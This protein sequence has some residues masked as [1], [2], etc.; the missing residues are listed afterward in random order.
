MAESTRAGELN[1][2]LRRLASALFEHARRDAS[3]RASTRA[4]IDVRYRNGCGSWIDKICIKTSD[5]RVAWLS[6]TNE[7]RLSLSRLGKLR[8]GDLPS[9]WCGLMLEVDSEGQ[10]TATWNYDPNC[11]EDPSFLQG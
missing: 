7:I 3:W 1:A 8:H 10:C 11:A 2:E 9:G 4:W 6:T 5:D